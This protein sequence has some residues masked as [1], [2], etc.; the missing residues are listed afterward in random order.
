MM[1]A[2]SSLL[3]FGLQVLERVNFHVLHERVELLAR[4]LVLVPL[5]GDADADLARH[6]PDARG[7]DL[8]VQQGVNAHLLI[9]KTT[10]S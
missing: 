1:S 4:V 10:P 2:R 9:D 3:V 7:P 8:P 5:A 6:V